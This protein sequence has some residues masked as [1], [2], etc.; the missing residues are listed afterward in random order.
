MSHIE[1]QKDKRIVNFTPHP[2]MRV[3]VDLSPEKHR[4]YM[5]RRTERYWNNPEYP[6]SARWNTKEDAINDLCKSFKPGEPDV[7]DGAS[8]VKDSCGA[9]AEQQPTAY[10]HLSRYGEVYQFWQVW[11]LYSSLLAGS[12]WGS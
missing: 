1:W 11:G 5:S 4:E 12:S 3:F 2:R 6:M 7:V 8:L 9:V 10:C